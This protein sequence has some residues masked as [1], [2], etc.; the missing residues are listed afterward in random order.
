MKAESP[1]ATWELW[2]VAMMLVSTRGDEAESH[3]EAKLAEA[4]TSDSEGDEIVWRGVLTQLAKIRA[5]R[6]G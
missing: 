2:S 3:A 6:Q 4:V 1:I 5:E